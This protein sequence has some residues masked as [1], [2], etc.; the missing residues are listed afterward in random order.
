MAF[1]GIAKKCKK[2]QSVHRP[3]FDEFCPDEAS[4]EKFSTDGVRP[5]PTVNIEIPAETYSDLTRRLQRLEERDRE[6]STLRE[7]VLVAEELCKKYG[8]SGDKPLSSSETETDDSSDSATSGYSNGRHQRRRARRTRARHSSKSRALKSSRLSHHRHLSKGETI[9]SIEK[10]MCVS[11]L[12]LKDLMSN[13]EDITGYVKHL[14]VLAEKAETRFYRIDSVVAY[15][16]AVRQAAAVDG[17]DTLKEIDSTLVMKHLGY[18]AAVGNRHQGQ[19]TQGLAKPK[20]EGY[21]YKFNAGFPCD[22]SKCLYRHVC[23]SC[24]DASHLQAVCTKGKASG[25]AVT[26]ANK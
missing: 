7:K 19:A 15:D 18:D 3:P 16:K 10:L 17:M 25:K 20:K 5:G 2:C 1:M 4:G 11:F 21:C 24:G 26:S 6:M 23:A 9:K 12:V 22:S 8:G 13:G 14:T